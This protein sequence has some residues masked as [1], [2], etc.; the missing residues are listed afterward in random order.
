MTNGEIIVKYKVR[1]INAKE[2]ENAQ[3]LSVLFFWILL[4]IN[5]IRKEFH[6]GVPFLLQEE[7]RKI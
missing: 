5:A 4:I 7:R 1:L 2:Q 6:L 3:R